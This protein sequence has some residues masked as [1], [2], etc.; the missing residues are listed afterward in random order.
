MAHIKVIVGETTCP[1]CLGSGEKKELMVSPKLLETKGRPRRPQP[2]DL[3]CC[4]RCMGKGKV[5][6]FNT[7]N[8]TFSIDNTYKY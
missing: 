2:F 3:N 1:E 7:D 4:R 8:V 5:P 6:V